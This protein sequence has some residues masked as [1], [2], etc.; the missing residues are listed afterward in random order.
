MVGICKLFSL[1]VEWTGYK[2]PVGL[3]FSAN[4]GNIISVL[5]L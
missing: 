1:F 4:I 5:Q 2:G 3:G